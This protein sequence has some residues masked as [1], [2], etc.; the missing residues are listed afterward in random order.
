MADFTVNVADPTLV[1]HASMNTRRLL[2]SFATLALGFYL[3]LSAEDKTPPAAPPSAGYKVELEMKVTEAG[4]VDDAKVIASDD[5]S[6]D[7][8]LERMAMETARTAKL[9][10]R[11]K[12]GK[13]VAYTA[14]AP[15]MFAVEG[16]EG[17]ASNKA[18][19]PSIHSAVQPVYPADLAAK[20]EVGGVIFEL[21]IGVDGKI[22]TMKLLRSSNP[23]FEQAATTALKQW[24][25]T[26]AKKDGVPVESRW[27]MAVSF[28]TDVLQADWVWRF[29]PRPSLGNYTVLHRTRPD[30]P[31]TSPAVPGKAPEPAKAPDAPVSK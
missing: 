26:P 14:R 11:I 25:F 7:H 5:T 6:V 21:V 3:S 15:F 22:S 23:K 28:E 10:P 20:G 13:A 4:T 16:D 31:A 2:P 29:P 9:A 19:K 18:P 24:V 27:R 12:D 8:V 1:Y 30:T 17:A